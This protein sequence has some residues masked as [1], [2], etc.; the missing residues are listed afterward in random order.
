MGSVSLKKKITEFASLCGLWIREG[1]PRRT[2]DRMRELYRQH[3]KACEKNDGG[4]CAA[5]QMVVSPT[6]TINKLSF[7]EEACPLGKFTRDPVVNPSDCVHLGE[8]TGERRSC[9]ICG[10]RH[11]KIPVYRCDLHGVCVQRRWSLKASDERLC[12][13]CVDLELPDGTKPILAM[14]EGTNKNPPT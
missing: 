11:L 1:R 3:C 4:F 10:G 2:K 12:L 8:P 7:V 13:R 6:K 9:E 14:R 5:D